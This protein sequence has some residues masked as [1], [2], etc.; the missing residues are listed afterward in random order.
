MIA[1]AP[2]HRGLE[3]ERLG[4]PKGK[5]ISIGQLMRAKA[6]DKKEGNTT[7]EREDQFAINARKW[8]K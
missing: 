5:K 8:N 7:G 6:R 3:H 1:I 4:V 2:S